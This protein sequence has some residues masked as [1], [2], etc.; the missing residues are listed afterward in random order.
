VKALKALTLCRF[1]PVLG[2][3]IF[4][5]TPDSMSQEE[6]DKIPSLMAIPA[7][8]FFIHT[9]KTFKTANLFIKLPNPIARGRV[10]KFLISIITEI[11][12]ALDLTIVKDFLEN[13]SHDFRNLEDAYKGLDIESKGYKGEIEKLNQIK[14][15]FYSFFKT[16]KPA[17]DALEISEHNLKER[18]K[19]LTCLY[20]LSELIDDPKNSVEDILQKTLELIPPA[21]QFPEITCAKIIY[22]NIE[23]ETEG[24]NDTP[25]TQM[26]IKEISGNILS[27]QVNYLEEKPFLKEEEAL[28][29]DIGNRLK[30][31]FEQKK[32]E[33]KLK[34]SEEKYRTITSS[35]LDAIIQI[36]DKGLIIYWN[37][38]A[39][40][41]FGYKMDE[42]LGKNF[43]D[44]ISPKRYHE[45]HKK[46]FAHFKTTGEGAA[47]GKT[48]ELAAITKENKEIPISKSI[49]AVKIKDKW[50]SIAIIRDITEQKE[51]EQK[52][53]ENLENSS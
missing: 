50:N 34:D 12:S 10:E 7:E 52:L 30:I 8:G 11:N 36:D 28:L 48:L 24:F 49:S 53:K 44:L 47:I 20:G 45:A 14:N 29:Q 1:D 13:F 6:L 46:G 27:I 5:K 23:Y 17:I 43:H 40:F 18:V 3:V 22:N 21:W 35:A 51:T 32:T 33:Q 42:I 4:L 15:L 41:I 37:K 9:F 26:V 25:W 2:T 19:E 31:S 38:A 16:I 39:E